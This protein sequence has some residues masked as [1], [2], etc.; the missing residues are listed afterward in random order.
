[1]FEYE[2]LIKLELSRYETFHFNY[3]GRRF[4]DSLI[5]VLNMLGREGWQ[6]VGMDGK[7]YILMR[8][9]K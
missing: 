2:R 5:E 3:D 1:M 7:N 8:E 4:G 6:L 9:K